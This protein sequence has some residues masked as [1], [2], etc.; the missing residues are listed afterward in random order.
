MTETGKLIVLAGATGDLGS[1]IADALM[2]NPEVRLRVLVR[3]QSVA[4]AASLRERGAEIVEVDLED[5]DNDAL[6]E[7]AVSGAFCV[8]SAIQGGPDVI[9]HAQLRLL[10]AARRAGVRRFIASNFS[11]NIFGLDHGDNI[12][13]DDRRAFARAAEEAK[14]DVELVQIQIGAFLDRKV[15]FG[16]LGAFD[17]EEGRAF[18]WGDGNEA[19]DFTTYADTALFTAE[20]AVDEATLPSVFEVA[21]ET[22]DFHGLVKAYEEGSGISVKVERMGTLADLDEEIERRRHAEPDNIFAWLSLMY[23][24]AMLS[25]KARLR[26]VANSRYPQIAPVGVAEYVRREGL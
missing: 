24:R 19:M 2:D 13:S 4:K 25:G 16:F 17:I 20:A 26:S 7:E 21:G 14:G 23:W 22:L 3:P 12:N 6:L 1:L 8:I 10:E 5:R 18:L 15:L 11:Y 9:I